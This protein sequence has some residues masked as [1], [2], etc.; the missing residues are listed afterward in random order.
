MRFVVLSFCQGN[1]W[2]HGNSDVTD[3]GEMG[4]SSSVSCNMHM[5]TACMSDRS[6]RFLLVTSRTQV[7]VATANWYI[8]FEIWSVGV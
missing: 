5:V 2:Y 7:D 8:L 1:G 4:W 3:H 6:T